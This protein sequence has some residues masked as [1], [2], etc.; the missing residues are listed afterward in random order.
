MIGANGVSSLIFM[1]NQQNYST[2][3]IN[4]DVTSWCVCID[5]TLQK[6]CH[7][8]HS[9]L[10]D[11][12]GRLRPSQFQIGAGTDITTMINW[13]MFT[14]SSHIITNTIK[15]LPSCICGL[16]AKEKRK[17]KQVSS[18]QILSFISMVLH[19]RERDAEQTTPSYVKSTNLQ[20]NLPNENSLTIGTL[21]IMWPWTNEFRKT[22]ITSTIVKVMSC[23][24]MTMWN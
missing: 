9:Q 17:F 13:W 16:S 23:H 18:M 19:A 22:L 8:R 11:T 2:Y 4:D 3:W 1:S 7:K 15:F 5:L 6:W 24:V 21:F 20:S 10:A 12:I 14:V